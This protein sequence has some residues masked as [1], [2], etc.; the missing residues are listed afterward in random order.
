MESNGKTFAMMPYP[1]DFV[2]CTCNTNKPSNVRCKW[3]KVKNSIVRCVRADKAKFHDD[4]DSPAFYDD[5]YDS[6]Y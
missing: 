1:T 6:E 4:G 5:M 2:T 3:M